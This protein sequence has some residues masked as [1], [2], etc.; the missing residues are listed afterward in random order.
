[1]YLGMA[2]YTRSLEGTVGVVTF[3]VIIYGMVIVPPLP[4]AAP[5]TEEQILNYIPLIGGNQATHIVRKE[6]VSTPVGPIRCFD[7]NL[8]RINHF[9]KIG[10]EIRIPVTPPTPTTMMMMMS[11][12][13]PRCFD[14][15]KN[16]GT[17]VAIPSIRI[18]I[19]LCTFGND[20]W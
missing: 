8:T 17:V 5:W 11:P 7:T 20:L 15:H 9:G 13:L 4:H 1:M 12:R 2:D 10:M 14:R 19:Q 18:G 6:L 3:V 16:K